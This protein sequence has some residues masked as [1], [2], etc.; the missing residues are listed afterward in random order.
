M[1]LADNL[2]AL[3]ALLN[4]MSGVALVAGWAMIRSGRAEA[5][6]RA[7]LSAFGISALFLVS[8]LARVALSGTHPYPDDAPARTFYL[9]MLAS[10][11]ILAAFV[12]FLSIGAI[13]MAFKERWSAH[14]KLVKFALPIWLYVSVTG[15][16]V[17]VMLY[18]V[19]GV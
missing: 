12:P 10:H 11:V 13:V 1:E 19:A 5:H 9:V 2:A 4:G 8:Y 17:Y 14:K 3:N 15:V 6:K 16:G 7:M 18:H